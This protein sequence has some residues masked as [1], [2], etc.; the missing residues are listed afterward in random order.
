MLSL[1][2]VELET[3]PAWCP[4]SQLT[5]NGDAV[6]ELPQLLLCALAVFELHAHALG[7]LL[8]GS[9]FCADVPKV[10][11]ELAQ[12]VLHGRQDVITAAD[13]QAQHR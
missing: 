5:W 12:H 4:G 3:C 13:L 9:D 7:L 6:N 10:R 1:A 11:L 2:T 8:Q